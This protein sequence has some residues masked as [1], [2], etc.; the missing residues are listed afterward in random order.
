MHLA[1]MLRCQCPS[2]Y[3]GSA[4]WSRCMPGSREVSSR[5]M[6]ATARLSCFICR[7]FVLALCVGLLRA[8]R[9][10]VCL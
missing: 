9:P 2:V 7:A 5:A 8:R 10:S 1:L 4:L 6:L 3:D